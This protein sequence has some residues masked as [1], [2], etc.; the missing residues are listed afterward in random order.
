MKNTNAVNKTTVE[1][2]LM[3]LENQI[4]VHIGIFIR[5]NWTVLVAFAVVIICAYGFELFNFN[6]T[7]DEENPM[8]LSPSL[9]YVSIGRWGAYVLN[10]LLLPNSTIPFVPLFLGLVFQAAAAMLLLSSLGSFSNIEKIIFGCILLTFPT[11]AYMGSFSLVNYTI[12]FGYFCIGLSLYVFVKVPKHYQ[13]FSILPAAFAIAIYQGLI[14]TLISV[15]LVYLVFF[16]IK[17]GRSKWRIILNISVILILSFSLY[18]VVDIFMKW[19][20]NAPASGYS[21]SFLMPGA[22]IHDFRNVMKR[23]ISLIVGIYSG[24][25]SIYADKISTLPY[26]ILLSL[27]GSWYIIFKSESSKITKIALAF[28]IPLVLFIPF[29]LGLVTNGAIPLRSLQDVPVVVPCVITLAIKDNKKISQYVIGLLAFMVIFQSVVSNNHLFLS[30]NLT[31]QAD[32]LLASRIINRIDQIRGTATDPI[33]FLEV[34]GS[35]NTVYPQVIHRSETIGGSF[36]EWDQGNAQRVTLFLSFIGFTGLSPSGRR[37]EIVAVAEA[38]PEWPAAGSVSAYKDTI[39]LKFGPYNA[40]QKYT[41]CYYEVYR[42][43]VP[44]GFCP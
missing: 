29:M 44:Q 38:M 14:P 31:L 24:A 4:T 8:F 33:N 21:E 25:Q 11:T 13:Y 37:G 20:L 9:W 27:L 2:T 39:I 34:V 23:L 32:K 26:L 40:Y 42:E 3:K 12:G 22:L 17:T 19:I 1:N 35:P 10:Y 36:F 16:T 18:F 6:L 43:T 41:I 30:S 7:I 28:A 5:E 15:Y